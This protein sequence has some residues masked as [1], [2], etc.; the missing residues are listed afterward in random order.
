MQRVGFDLTEQTMKQFLLVLLALAGLAVGATSVSAASKVRI[1]RRANTL[2]AAYYSPGISRDGGGIIITG[3]G[4]R[5]VP[6]RSPVLTSRFASTIRA[7][8]VRAR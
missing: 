2:G 3:S 6:P 8:G 1:P 7:G 4:I 5:R